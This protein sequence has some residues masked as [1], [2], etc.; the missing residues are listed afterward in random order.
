MPKLIGEP[1]EDTFDS[2]SVTFGAIHFLFLS[3]M[4]V[5]GIVAVIYVRREQIK[6]GKILLETIKN[7]LS[8]K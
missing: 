8:Q 4:I 1:L 2:E 3:G 6:K 7:Q 5:F